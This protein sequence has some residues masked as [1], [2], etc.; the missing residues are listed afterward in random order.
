MVVRARRSDRTATQAIADHLK[1]P[2]CCLEELKLSWNSIRLE[3]GVFLA[4]AIAFNQS[5]RVLDLSYNAIGSEGGKIIGQSL[6][7]NKT[8]ESLNLANNN[9][10]AE[11]CF[12]MCA[13]TEHNFT[14]KLLCLDGN[15]IGEMGAKTIMNSPSIIGGRC[16]VSCLACNTGVRLKAGAFDEME[17][18]GL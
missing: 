14:L 10:D 15:P 8:M 2:D 7:E 6:Y 3:S 16:E 4:G 5:L 9:I 1:C 13:A 18:F 11:A 17:P 12:V